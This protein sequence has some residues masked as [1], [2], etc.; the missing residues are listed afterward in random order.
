MRE[1]H[2]AAFQEFDSH[3]VEIT[4]FFMGLAVIV[5]GLGSAIY[6]MDKAPSD[7]DRHRQIF[8]GL[9][10]CSGILFLMGLLAITKQLILIQI[11]RPLNFF[12]A[13]AS[14]FLAFVLGNFL[15]F[16]LPVAFVV[17]ST[18]LNKAVEAYPGK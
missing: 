18:R 1:S 16:I 10:G 14:G 2:P 8:T 17:V 11:L 13:F 4:G 6:F 12:L 9:L 15:L 3:A 5:A 7:P